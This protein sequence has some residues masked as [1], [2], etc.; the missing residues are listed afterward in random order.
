MGATREVKSAPNAAPIVDVAN[1]A[2]ALREWL[3]GATHVLV[4]AG[5]GMTAAAGVDYG[6]EADFA[7][8]FHVLHAKGFRARY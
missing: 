3:S 2:R 6:D 1:G 7:Q 8:T 4:G 5:A